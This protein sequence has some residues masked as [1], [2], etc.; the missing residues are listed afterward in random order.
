MEGLA[1][2][3]A[4][5]CFESDRCRGRLIERAQVLRPREHW[6]RVCTQGID[7]DATQNAATLK[8]ECAKAVLS[9]T[10]YEI[11]EDVDSRRRFRL[12]ADLEA[13]ARAPANAT[14]C[15]CFSPSQLRKEVCGLRR[16]MLEH[17]LRELTLLLSEW[18]SSDGF[19]HDG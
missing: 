6:G 2:I 18:A 7:L 19:A 5:L 4:S 9:V 1:V 14:P 16:A 12:A 13:E 10:D 8:D 3:A 11:S 17:P 15:G